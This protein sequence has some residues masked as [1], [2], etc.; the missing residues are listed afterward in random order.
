MFIIFILMLINVIRINV[1]MG[2]KLNVIY[3]ALNITIHPHDDKGKVYVNLFKFLARKA[4][5]V[6]GQDFIYMYGLT[7][8]NERDISQGFQ[9]T[10]VKCTK[11][12]L[13][14]FFDT[15]T[16]DFTEIQDIEDLIPD[17]TF[18]NARTFNFIFF[19]S[20]HLLVTE[21][22][23]K[24]GSVTINTLAKFFELA[25][26]FK[27]VIDKFE[28]LNVYILPDPEKVEALIKMKNIV[29]ME[30]EIT[31]PNPDHLNDVE[32]RLHNKMKRMNVDKIEETYISSTKQ[33]IEPDEETKNKM[34]VAAKNGK[35]EVKAID[36]NGK[37][38]V[39]STEAIPFTIQDEYDSKTESKIDLLKRTA[40]KIFAKF[41]A[42]K[43]KID[44]SKAD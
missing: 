14:G 5:R 21:I 7:P 19:P 3:G 13:D 10:F 41:N 4:I 18:A 20:K 44:D 24:D 37:R 39:Y 30:L 22:K 32:S 26:S 29:S 8:L 38:K 15:K 1:K 25:F 42:T 36:M 33:F 28:N 35:V 31:R 17:G 2:K 16:D 11:I 34:R 23:D 9:G 27:E 43:G 6:R 40:Q 12:E